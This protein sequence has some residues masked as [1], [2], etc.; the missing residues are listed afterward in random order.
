MR[1]RRGAGD[2][3]RR[4][5]RAW[6]TAA[7]VVAAWACAAGCASAQ[8]VRAESIP[9]VP[10]PGWTIPADSVSAVFQRSNLV[11]EHP[12]M[13]GVYPRDLVMLVFR[14]TATAAQRRRAVDAVGGTLVGGDGAY[15][16]IRVKAPC[17]DVPVW[18]AVD[19]LEK[20]PQ[21]EAA[22]PFMLGGKPAGAPGAR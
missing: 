22:H 8:N 2:L 6:R 17:A 1:G 18:C 3:P 4:R 7:L 20:L 10:P 21:V 12:R 11:S 13:S 16:F 14:P 15:W 9:A 5:I 19:V